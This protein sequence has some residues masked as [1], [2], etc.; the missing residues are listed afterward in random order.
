MRWF[1]RLA[2]RA[3][4]GPELA[5]SQEPSAESRTIEVTAYRGYGTGAAVKDRE[6]DQDESARAG[7]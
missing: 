6:P 1:R 2:D 7:E 3:G 4:A 5:E